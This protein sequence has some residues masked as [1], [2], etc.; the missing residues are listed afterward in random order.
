MRLFVLLTL[1]GLLCASCGNP[2]WMAESHQID[3]NGWSSEAPLHFSWDVESADQSFDLVLDVRHSQKYPF[4]NLYLFCTYQFPNGK[5]R[6]DTIECTLADDLGKWRGRGF[7][8]LVEQRFMLHQ[9]I[10]FPSSGQHGMRI[11]HGM[12]QDPIS[13]IASIGLRLEAEAT[14]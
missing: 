2:P 9:G 10:S 3:M 14:P 12:R 8:D 6:V 5:T 4:S 13:G 11:I 1:G 7:G